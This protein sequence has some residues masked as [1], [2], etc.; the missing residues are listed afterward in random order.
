[1]VDDDDDEALIILSLLIETGKFFKLAMLS[2]RSGRADDLS[3][4]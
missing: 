1:M 4:N 2:C 3:I